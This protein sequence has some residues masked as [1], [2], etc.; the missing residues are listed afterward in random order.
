MSLE[1]KLQKKFD[2]IF[3]ALDEALGIAA[4]LIFMIVVGVLI[5]VTRLIWPLTVV[6]IVY[7]IWGN[8]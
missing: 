3:A 2:A 5:L 8:A 6:A 1:N 4:A 7:M